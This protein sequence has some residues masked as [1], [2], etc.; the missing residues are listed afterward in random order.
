M[1]V[2]AASKMRSPSQAKC[3]MTPDAEMPQSTSITK[4]SPIL[5]MALLILGV[6]VFA[7]GLQYK[8]SLYE[9]PSNPHPVSV[10]KL[11]QGEQT[12][13]KISSIQLG[14]RYKSSLLSVQSTVV[15]FVPRIIGRRNRQVD[16]VVCR[17]I[18]FV[19]CFLFFRPPPKIS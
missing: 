4:V 8:L 19:P 3:P 16:K 5:R 10:A 12:N 2:N 15:T 1:R 6:A 14:N 7:W 18:L 9:A 17:S 13:K 11:I